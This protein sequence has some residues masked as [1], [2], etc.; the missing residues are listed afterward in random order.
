MNKYRKKALALLLAGALLL[1][2]G[3][4]GLEEAQ[5]GTPPARTEQESPLPAEN[6]SED[7]TQ[8]AAALGSLASFTAADLD[9]EPFTQDDIAAKDVTVLNF[10]STTCVPCLVEMPDLAAFAKALPETVQVVTVCLDGWGNEEAVRDFLAEAGFEGTTL[11]AGDGDFLDL[12]GNLLYTPTTV[13]A[14]SQGQ[15]VGDALIGRQAELSDVYLDAVNQ[16]LEAGGKD[17]ITLA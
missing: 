11:V 3:C 4:G 9:G 2:A 13:F 5:I 12:C 1:L 8:G 16:V 7:E 17:A 14:D 6:S 10:W 15:L